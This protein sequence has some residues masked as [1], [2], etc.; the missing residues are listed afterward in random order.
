VDDQDSKGQ[1]MIM[2]M[3][4]SEEEQV[5]QEDEELPD[6]DIGTNKMG[7][8]VVVAYE[9]QWFIVEVCRD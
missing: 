1:E 9:G 5:S 3:V 8:Y 7:S 4:E 6:L 2:A